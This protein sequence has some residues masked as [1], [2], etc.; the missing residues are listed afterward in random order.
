MTASAIEA[1]LLKIAPTKKSKDRQAYLT[2]LVNSVRE[3]EDDDWAALSNEAQTYVNKATAAQNNSKELPD[4]PDLEDDGAKAKGNGAD[5]PKEVKAERGRKPATKATEKVA[6]T[7][8]A[9]A[10]AKTPAAKP[11]KAGLSA[12]Q[13]VKR[14]LAKK[15]KLS[16]SDLKD[17][18]DK[19]GL[20]MAPTS[21][22]SIR[23]DTLTTMKVLVELGM[24]EA[25]V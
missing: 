13:R 1:E 4:F 3:A 8:K 20:E 17:M 21:I 14:W 19:E 23:S 9:K 12:V 18:L 16:I 24:L 7:A 22:S 10:V 2:K 6:K 25:D 15:P 11:A 5:Q